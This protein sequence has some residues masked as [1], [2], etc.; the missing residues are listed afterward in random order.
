MD[1]L[2]KDRISFPEIDHLKKDLRVS[3][4]GSGAEVEIVFVL[5]FNSLSE[6]LPKHFHFVHRQ[7]ILQTDIAVLLI[8]T[9]LI[10]GEW[11]V[12]HLSSSGIGILR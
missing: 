1:I 7:D 5:I 4:V 8:E 9:N 11:I 12:I 2:L 10:F 3:F 6:R